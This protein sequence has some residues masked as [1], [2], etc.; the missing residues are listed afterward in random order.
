MKYRSRFLCFVPVVIL[1][2][3]LLPPPAQAQFRQQGPKLVGTGAPTDAGEGLSVSISNDG[4]TAIVGGTGPTVVDGPGGAAW[5]FRR[6]GEVWTQ[7]AKLVGTGA[8]G[9]ADQGTS[10]S[11][12]SDG[13]T[14]I[15]G[16][17]GDNRDAGAAWVFTR[18]SRVWRQQAKLVAEGTSF[19][20]GYSVS[21]SGNGNT[22][23][24][25]GPLDNGSAGAA[26]VFV[27][28]RGVWSQQAKL[29]GTGV[30]GGFATQGTSVSLSA[31]G[32]TAIVGGFNDN[33]G[34]G[35]AWVFVRSHR[36]WAQQ[37]KLV[38]T[39]AVGTAL[40]GQS[41]S[42]SDD[43]NTV[44]VGGPEDNGDVGAVWV[45]TRSHGVWTQQGSKLVGTGVV[46]SFA[47]QGYSVSLSGNGNAAIV[48]GWADNNNAGAA[49]VFSRSGGL[50]T[51]QGPKL[52][53]TGAV[54]NALQGVGVSLS[55]DADTAVVGGS[56]D[57]NL[58]GA[59]WIFTQQPVF[60]GT[61]GRANCHDQSVSVLARQFGGL[62]AA[63]AALGFASVDAL[64]SAVLAFCEG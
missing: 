44:I 20:F 64:Q 18:S 42:I 11:L 35:A 10:V 46:G 2:C 63:A 19:L 55:G 21:L 38:G 56:D 17:P 22:A 36:V 34:V 48:G 32:N 23:I 51:Q 31:D 57:N 27:R 24:V 1:A 50:W 45:F 37:A 6:S 40:Q 5:V 47:L 59:A 8:I 43:G 26:W 58:L 9:N 4:N 12:S 53:G 52:V 13:N 61:P 28:S 7:Q 25:G 16:G 49:W 15:A 3:S 60:A 39:E 33:N 54:G 29:V 62:D 30:T 41:V 14:A